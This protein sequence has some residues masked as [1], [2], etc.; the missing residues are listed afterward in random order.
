MGN[1][2]HTKMEPTPTNYDKQLAHLSGNHLA[3]NLC[4]RGSGPEGHSKCQRAA[5][6][7]AQ[8]S[9]SQQQVCAEAD[10]LRE[11]W[12]RWKR[13]A[14]L[15]NVAKDEAARRAHELANSKDECDDFSSSSSS[16]SLFS[17]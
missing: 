6:W 14:H 11:K 8:D 9:R 17:T 16:S 4:G 10:R 15:E 12:A 1:G 7:R 3:C 13:E 5:E 2:H